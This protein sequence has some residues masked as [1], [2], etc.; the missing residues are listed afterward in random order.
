[1]RYK[2]LKFIKT[3]NQKF[4][5]KRVFSLAA[6]KMGSKGPRKN[7]DFPR[8]VGQDLKKKIL[9][10]S[11]MVVQPFFRI[12]VDLTWNDQCYLLMHLYT[13]LLSLSKLICTK[14]IIFFLNSRG[15]RSNIKA[16][17]SCIG[18]ISCM[19]VY[20]NLV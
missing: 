2:G 19:V 7:L 20:Q 1:M 14:Y 12:L 11:E 18:A 8:I 3:Q 10:H 16:C 5:E 17:Y 15:L 13:L 9:S 6:C 4:T